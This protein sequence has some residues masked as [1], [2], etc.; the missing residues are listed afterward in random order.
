MRETS[1]RVYILTVFLWS[2]HSIGTR[3]R[4]IILYLLTMIH[5]VS[6]NKKSL[7]HF[8]LISAYMAHDL[9]LNTLDGVL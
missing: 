3:L 1:F 8:R 4:S 2:M 6:H 9:L 5:T 7:P